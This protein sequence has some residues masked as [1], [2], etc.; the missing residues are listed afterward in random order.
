MNNEINL[1]KQCSESDFSVNF[2]CRIS[3]NLFS[4]AELADRLNSAGKDFE[5][6]GKCTWQTE[7]TVK[8]TL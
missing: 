8:G 4:I 6:Q 7:N 3:R 2:R 1:K 5:Q